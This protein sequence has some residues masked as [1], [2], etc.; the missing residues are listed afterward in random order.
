MEEI[1]TLLIFHGFHRAIRYDADG[2]DVRRYI[3]IAKGMAL[4]T[5]NFVEIKMNRVDHTLPAQRR[6]MLNDDAFE[7]VN[8][9]LGENNV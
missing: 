9:F 2:M 3:K 5:P 8:K 7:A 6:I 4:L 1:G